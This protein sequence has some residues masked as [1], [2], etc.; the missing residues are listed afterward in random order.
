MAILGLQ[1]SAEVREYGI[2]QRE[3]GEA[4]DDPELLRLATAYYQ[5]TFDLFRSGE[6]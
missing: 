3:V 4:V 5:T 2:G 6:L 1:G